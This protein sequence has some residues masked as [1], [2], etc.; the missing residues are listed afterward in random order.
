[1]FDC[2]WRSHGKGRVGKYTGSTVMLLKYDVDDVG[3]DVARIQMFLRTAY[4]PRIPTRSYIG[5]NCC[6]GKTFNHV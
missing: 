1:M 3:D 2:E 6:M 4:A 5:M